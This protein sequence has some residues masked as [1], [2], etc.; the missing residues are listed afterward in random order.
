VGVTG[1]VA[2][3]TETVYTLAE[4]LGIDF[5]KWYAW[6]GIWSALMHFALAIFNACELVHLVTRFSCEVFGCLIAL[7]YIW[8]AIEQL[9]NLTSSP[10]GQPR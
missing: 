8:Q 7:I 2:I 9:V 6:I 3:F 4:S 10:M 5:M 1:P